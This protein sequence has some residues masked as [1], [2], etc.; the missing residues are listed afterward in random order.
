VSLLAVAGTFGLFLWERDQG[1]SLETARTIAVNMLVVFEAF[2]I[3]NA[4]F[5]YG[6]VLSRQGLL[7]NPYVPLTIGIVLAMQG[8]FTYTEVMHTLFQ[9]TG[10]DV[11]AWMRIVGIG[12]MIFFLVELEKY[13]F[14]AFLH[15][16][17]PEVQL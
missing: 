7:G 12:A 11:L 8:L 17:I 15:K 1:A 5:F 14:R 4:R 2:Y 10:I 16:E 9:T 6:S 3:L 13:V